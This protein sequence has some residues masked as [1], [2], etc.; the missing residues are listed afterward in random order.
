M[1]INSSSSKTDVYVC[2]MLS[3]IWML[4]NEVLKHLL[5]FHCKVINSFQSYLRME[6]VAAMIRVINLYANIIIL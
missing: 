2:N 1:E 5:L 3:F 6:R 4:Q